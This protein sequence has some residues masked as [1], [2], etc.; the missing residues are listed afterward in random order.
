MNYSESLTSRAEKVGNI[1]CVGLDPELDKLPS[2]G[3]KEFENKQNEPGKAIA[4]FYIN[5]LNAFVDSQVVPAIVKPNIAFYEQYGFE[6][7]KA[8]EQIIKE[9]KILNI[10]FILDAKRGDIG[11]TSKAYAKAMFDVWKADAVTI[12]PYM[13]NDSVLPFIEYCEKGKGVYVLVRTSNK[14]ARDFQNLF[15][16]SSV[17]ID[18]IDNQ[19]LY[20]KVAQKLIEWYKPGVCAVVGATSLQELEQISRYFVESGKEIPL[21]IPGVGAQG[22]SAKEVIQTL[23]R[24]G[25]DL[26]IHRINSSSGINYA[27]LDQKTDDYCGAAVKAL[28][29]LMEEARF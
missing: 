10:P 6:G 4:K 8:L 1:I 11:K 21:L 9:C 28:K 16:N 2:T 19:P 23:K 20:M 7:L 29:M 3:C 14:G 22:G 26:S 17:N 5:M 24:A 18:G 13:G 12:A 27:Y 15:V 25:C